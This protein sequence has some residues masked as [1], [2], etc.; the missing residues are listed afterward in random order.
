M[1]SNQSTVDFIVKQMQFAGDIS[2]R[3]MFGEY[4]LYCNGKMI[5]SVCD[6]KLFIKPTITGRAYIGNVVEASPYPMA[7]PSFLI[8][9]KQYQDSAWLIDLVKITFE[10][11]PMPVKKK[12][13]VKKKTN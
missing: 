8:S 9:E 13:A 6:D 1:P 5:G 12:K 11:L 7:K 3:K 10:E 4:A 2:F